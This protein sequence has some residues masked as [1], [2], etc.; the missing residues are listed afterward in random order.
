MLYEEGTGRPLRLIGTVLDVTEPQEGRSQSC[1]RRSPRKEILLREVNHRIKNNLQLVSSMLALQGGRSEHPEV[2]RLVQEAQARLQIVA[3]VHER[4]YLSE[5]I[6][7]VDLDVF[8]ETLCRDVER[9]GAGGRRRDRRGR[10]RRAGDDRQRPR[11]AGGADPERAPHQRHQICLSRAARDDRGEP[12]Q[13]RPTAGRRF[14]SPTAAS[15][16]PTNFAERQQ[17]LARLSHHRRPGAADPRRAR[18]RAALAG[19]ARSRSPS[20]PTGR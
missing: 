7:S 14:P 15:A 13:A 19:R 18:D 17:R 6:G 20:R 1:R 8:L 12:A 3:A 2:R 16:F 5:D 9:T 4:L 11:R 10:R